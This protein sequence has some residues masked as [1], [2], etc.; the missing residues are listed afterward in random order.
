MASTKLTR[1]KTY[2][3]DDGAKRGPMTISQVRFHPAARVLLAACADR[4]LALWNLDAKETTTKNL[5][6]VPG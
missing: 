6:A 5:T 3:V 4:R 1:L 2:H